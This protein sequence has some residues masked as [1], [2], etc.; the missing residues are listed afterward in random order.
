MELTIF[1]TDKCVPNLYVVDI[2][3]KVF[4]STS[5]QEEIYEWTNKLK[6]GDRISAIH[7]S[8]GLIE[9]F[10]I[11]KLDGE[12]ENFVGFFKN[13]VLHNIEPMLKQ[14]FMEDST[15]EQKIVF[16]FALNRLEHLIKMH[17]PFYNSESVNSKIPYSDEALQIVYY[18]LCLHFM[19][20]LM[21]ETMMAETDVS[22]W[23]TFVQSFFLGT[24]RIFGS[25]LNDIFEREGL[26]N[27][28]TK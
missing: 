10:I 26:S 25:N 7:E 5:K 27:T 21:H 22:I 14:G 2:V 12:Q 3:N 4:Q 13:G 28:V 17:A 16:G 15:N 11:G 1:L 23:Y 18:V 20:G 24:K 19:F 8:F 6:S 9:D